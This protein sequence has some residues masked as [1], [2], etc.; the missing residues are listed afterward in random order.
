MRILKHTFTALLG[1][2]I[3]ASFPLQAS[4][5]SQ[6]SAF[7][8]VPAEHWAAMAVRDLVEKYG[9]MSGFPD[10]TFKGTRS[11]SRY[12]AAAAFYKVMLQL[13]QV[14]DLTR[15]I[16]NVT[17]EDLKTMKALTEEFQQEIE[18]FKKQQGENTEK[19][20]ELEKSL[21]KLKED[22]GSVRFGGRLA[23]AIEDNFQDNFRPGYY[24][25]YNLSMRIAAAE[26][27]TIRSTLTGSFSSIQETNDKDEIKENK[28]VDV[29]FAQ[30]WFDHQVQN[31]FLNPR[32]KFGYMGS[33][34]LITPYMGIPHQFD[35][36]II[37]RLDADA[38]SNASPNLLSGTHGIRFSRSFI[39]GSAFNEGFFN[40]AIAASPDIFYAQ[41]GMNFFNDLFK[42]KLISEADQAMFFGDAVLDTLNNHT[43]MLELGTPDIGLGMQATFRGLANELNFRGASAN[44]NFRLGG[45]NLGGS[46]KFVSEKT[47]E[48][49]YAGIYVSS[50]GNLKE[51]N[52]E[53]SDVSIPS[54]LFAIQSPFT[55]QNGQIFEGSS[56]EVGDLAGFLVQMAYDN[57]IIPNLTLE[58]GHRQKVFLNGVIGDEKFDKTTIAIS[59]EF[60]F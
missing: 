29:G 5:Q 4:S 23:L 30:A 49:I 48:Q 59:S 50:P 27:T 16:G 41:V 42:V 13:S 52:P 51:I 53:W 12:E 60:Y 19:I 6:T 58:L 24:T 9:V 55:V 46:G 47:Y 15:R 1:V 56:D 3:L 43:A 38:V 36:S 8:D 33:N 31:T 37:F 26:N 40:G 22:L 20:Q 28:S 57:P 2:S 25:N 34:N 32:V 10:Q 18:T 39:A 45:F 44:T 11:I 17:L 21:K 14:E 35:S 54:F 7:G